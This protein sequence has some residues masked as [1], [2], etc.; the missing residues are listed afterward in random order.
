MGK[1]L[2]DGNQTGMRNWIAALPL[3]PVVYPP[4]TSD[5]IPSFD[6]RPYQRPAWFHDTRILYRVWVRLL[7]KNAIIPL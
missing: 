5:V 6:T 1:D 7:S 4:A 2:P 3:F